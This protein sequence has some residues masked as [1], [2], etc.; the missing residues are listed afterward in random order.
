MLETKGEESNKRLCTVI[1]RHYIKNKARVHICVFYFF[2]RKKKKK[3]SPSNISYDL[4]KKKNT[5]TVKYKMKYIKTAQCYPEE[6][7]NSIK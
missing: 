3:N 7:G 4:I 2:A 6:I 5:T 1:E